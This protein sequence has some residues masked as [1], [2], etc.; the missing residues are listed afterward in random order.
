M[1]IFETTHVLAKVKTVVIIVEIWL[2]SHN[3]EVSSVTPNPNWLLSTCSRMISLVKLSLANDLFRNHFTIVSK[4]FDMMC[5]VQLGPSIMWFFYAC[6]RCSMHG[7]SKFSDWLAKN[8][9]FLESLPSYREVVRMHYVAGL[10]NRY[11]KVVRMLQAAACVH[12]I[13]G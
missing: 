7:F 4:Y 11:R 2:G 8:W 1:A 12:Y 5:Y 9:Y 13:A 10:A 6:C 3:F